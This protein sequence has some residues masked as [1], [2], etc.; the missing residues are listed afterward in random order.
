MLFSSVIDVFQ[1]LHFHLVQ[2]ILPILVSPNVVII[3]FPYLYSTQDLQRHS[4]SLLTIMKELQVFLK[5]QVLGGG[6]KKKEFR[7]GH[8]SHKKQS[9]KNRV[10]GNC[11]LKKEIMG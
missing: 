10:S 11:C 3:L 6:K 8:T 4:A 5:S 2:N 9:P 7:L 1:S